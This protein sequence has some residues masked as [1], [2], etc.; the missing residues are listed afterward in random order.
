[1]PLCPKNLVILQPENGMKSDIEV[2]I[3]ELLGKKSNAENENEL[4]PPLIFTQID[5][6]T[7]NII[8]EQGSILEENERGL[9]NSSLIQK[10]VLFNTKEDLQMALK[11]LQKNIFVIELNQDIHLDM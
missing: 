11:I 4:V 5:W 1:M 7:N 8:C 2:E 10:R 9:E 3:D 6:G